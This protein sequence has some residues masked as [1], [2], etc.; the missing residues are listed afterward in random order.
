MSRDHDKD[1]HED[2]DEDEEDP[3]GSNLAVTIDRITDFD[4]ETRPIT[5]G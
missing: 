2:D 5:K 4:S 1:D 3:A